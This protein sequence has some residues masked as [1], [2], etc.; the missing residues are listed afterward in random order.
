[1]VEGHSWR[2]GTPVGVTDEGKVCK[3]RDNKNERMR[4]LALLVLALLPA[5]AAIDAESPEQTQQ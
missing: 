5:A 4:S 3:K 2:T 1:M